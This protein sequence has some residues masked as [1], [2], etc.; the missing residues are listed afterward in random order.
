VP[1][2]S[3][4]ENDAERD[5]LESCRIAEEAEWLRHAEGFAAA[6]VAPAKR[7]R[8]R[9]LLTRRPRRFA[10]DSHKLHADL[11]RRVCRPVLQLPAA[12]QGDGLFYGFFDLPRVVPAARAAAAAGSGD[13]VFFLVPGELA[14]YFFHEGEVWLCQ[15]MR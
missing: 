14:V 4:A 7:E 3:A 15:A 6:F 12:I 10:R 13:A 2:R 9:E 11:D 1:Y 5:V 8:W